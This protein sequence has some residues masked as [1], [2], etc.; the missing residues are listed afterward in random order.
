MTDEPLPTLV[1]VSQSFVQ[2][3]PSQRLLDEIR[4]C[5]P[6]ATFGELAETQP[7]RALV[8]DFPGRDM[9]SLWLHAYDV[10]V[11]VSEADPTNG[12]PATTWPRSATTGVVFPT[13]STP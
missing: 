9:T 3:L 10:E 6:A 12:K 8:R 2:R 4:H 13:P 1:K 5:E 11:D 7:F